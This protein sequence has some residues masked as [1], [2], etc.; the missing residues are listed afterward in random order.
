MLD[1]SGVEFS[2]EFLHW[3]AKQ[4]DQLPRASEGTTLSAAGAAL[5]DLGQPDEVA[6]PYDEQ[7]DP[8]APTY[9]PPDDAIVA[10]AARR[11]SMG[12]RLEPSADAIRAAIERDE[13]VALGIRLFSTWHFLDADARID[14]PPPRATALGGHAVLVVGFEDGSAIGDGVFLVRN[15]WG[16]GWGEAGYAYLPYAYVDAHALSAWIIGP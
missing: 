7:R 13:V 1:G 14:V 6:W 10:A 8:W 9:E 16:A 4:R 3:G 12:L 2:V 15:S 11:L 5:A